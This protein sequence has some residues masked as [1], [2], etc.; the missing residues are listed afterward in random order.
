MSPDK[1]SSIKKLMIINDRQVSVLICGTTPKVSM[2][3]SLMPDH[4][5]VYSQNS[6]QD[7]CEAILL[8]SCKRQNGD[9]HYMSICFLNEN[10]SII[11]RGLCSTMH[12]RILF[13]EDID[14]CLSICSR[15]RRV[16]SPPRPDVLLWR[17]LTGTDQ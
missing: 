12:G 8:F 1:L 13:G 3:L 10:R 6:N 7:I 14:L 16:L 4:R 2:M 17:L 5:A 9:Y 15:A 11:W